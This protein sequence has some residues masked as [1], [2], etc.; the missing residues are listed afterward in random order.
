LLLLYITTFTIILLTHKSF[1]WVSFSYLVAA[2]VVTCCFKSYSLELYL[3]LFLFFLFNPSVLHYVFCLFSFLLWAI[4]CSLQPAFFLCR[5]INLEG[6]LEIIQC[7]PF[8]LVLRKLG[9]WEVKVL[10]CYVWNILTTFLQQLYY[11]SQIEK[12]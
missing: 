11:I 9:A 3:P 7:K 12:G 5:I 6:T 2:S 4:W 8:L 10:C 1:L